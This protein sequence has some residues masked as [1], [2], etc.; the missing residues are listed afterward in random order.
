[1]KNQLL[2]KRALSGT[3]FLPRKTVWLLSLGC[4]TLPLGPA[5]ANGGMSVVIHP[6][7]PVLTPVH[8]TVSST[9]TYADSSMNSGFNTSGQAHSRAVQLSGHSSI[10]QLGKTTGHTT[11]V[12]AVISNSSVNHSIANTTGSSS[13][14]RVSSLPSGAFE[15]NLSSARSNIVLGSNLFG[16]AQTVTINVG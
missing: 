6:T 5:Y 2:L 1:M 14:P 7:N 12:N 3:Q 15:L 11:A 10:G 4:F 8:H 16:S 13:T 9:G